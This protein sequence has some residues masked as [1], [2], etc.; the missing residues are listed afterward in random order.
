[1]IGHP[2]GI[3]LGAVLVLLGIAGPAPVSTKYKIE[4]KIETTIDLSAMGQGTQQ[5]NVSQS[6]FISIAMSDTAGGKVVH[7]VIDSLA[8]DAPIPGAAEAMAKA[9]GPG[10]TV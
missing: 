2:A 5:Q 8:T 10:S 4:T 3:S 6:A 9:R 1:M 7:V